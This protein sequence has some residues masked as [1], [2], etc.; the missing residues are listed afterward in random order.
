L[1][2]TNTPAGHEAGPNNARGDEQRGKT[3]PGPVLAL[4]TTLSTAVDKSQ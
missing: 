2:L 1:P 4:S 3:V